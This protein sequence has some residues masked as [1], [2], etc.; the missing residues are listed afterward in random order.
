[1]GVKSIVEC[2]ITIIVALS[3]LPLVL[4]SIATASVSMEGAASVLLNLVPLFYVVGIILAVV[5][6]ALHE[7][8]HGL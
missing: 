6:Y 8:G 5:A 1:M 4:S 3:L 7:S 2:V